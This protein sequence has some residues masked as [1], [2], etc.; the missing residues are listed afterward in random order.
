MSKNLPS[1]WNYRVCHVRFERAHGF[2]SYF[3]IREVH[4][5]R[6]GDPC[7]ASAESQAPFGDT[8]DEL[9]DDLKWMLEAFEKPTIHIEEDGNIDNQWEAA[10]TESER[11]CP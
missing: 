10:L 9:K 8:L 5:N 2:S 4:Y 6:E 7:A 3:D 1:T 11:R